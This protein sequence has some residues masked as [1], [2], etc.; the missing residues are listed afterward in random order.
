[1]IFK[2]NSTRHHRGTRLS[3]LSVK[4]GNFT[5]AQLPTDPPRD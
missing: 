3:I 2:S 1:M 4:Q 5:T